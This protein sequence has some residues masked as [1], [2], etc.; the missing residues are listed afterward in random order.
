MKMYNLRYVGTAIP[1]AILLS[2]GNTNMRSPDS[3]ASQ[4]TSWLSGWGLVVIAAFIFFHTGAASV[5]PEWIGITLIIGFAALQ[6]MAEYPL[7]TV[8]TRRKVDAEAVGDD[9][10]VRCDVCGNLINDG[11]GE[12]RRYARQQ[13][14][15]G[16]PLRTLGWGVNTYCM[17]CESP[18]TSEVRAAQPT[19]AAEADSVESHDSCIDDSTLSHDIE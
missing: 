6:N 16:I 5:I 10:H 1:T 2:V 17:A 15:F 14:A 19:D 9:D 13:V 3:L 4:A 18:I 12:H 11:E 8:G 7:T